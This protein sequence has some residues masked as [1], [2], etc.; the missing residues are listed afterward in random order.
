MSLKHNAYFEV[1]VGVCDC[2]IAEPIEPLAEVHI[3][4]V[5]FRKKNI[6]FYTIKS[7]ISCIIFHVSLHNQNVIECIHVYCNF[8]NELFLL[9]VILYAVRIF[10]NFEWK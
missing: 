5:I 8:Q 3:I 10:N 9:L 4:L 2:G 7:C 6:P 1:R